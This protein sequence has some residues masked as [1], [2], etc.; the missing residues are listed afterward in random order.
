LSS[1]SAITPQ[2]YQCATP[3][4][5]ETQVY[6]QRWITTTVDA[7]PTEMDYDILYYYQ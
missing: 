2:S 3:G 5:G 4:T 1:R 7:C 6:L